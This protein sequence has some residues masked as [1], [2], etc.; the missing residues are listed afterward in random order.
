[1]KFIDKKNI[2]LDKVPTLLDKFVVD[3]V[4]ILQKHANYVIVSGYVSILFGRSRATEDIDI[5]V[6][7]MPKKRFYNFYSNLQKSG[8]WCVN[9]E[10]KDEILKILLDGLAVRLAK[11]SRIIP[12]VEFKFIKNAIEKNAI[13]TSIN[14][15]MP[16]GK[17]KISNI[18]LQI[19]YKEKVLK[20]E[21]DLEDARHLEEIFKDEI[22]NKLLGKYRKMLK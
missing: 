12:N 6:E 18:E 8:Y 19:A 10:N 5:L 2:K 17:I 14:V 11:K 15:I 4:K 13:K 9:T 16:S 7:R 22:S 20:S 21:K 3:F 1:M